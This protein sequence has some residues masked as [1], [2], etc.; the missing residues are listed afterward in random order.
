MHE[1]MYYMEAVQKWGFNGQMTAQFCPVTEVKDIAIDDKSIGLCNG[2]FGHIAAQKKWGGFVNLADTLIGMEY[3]TIGLGCAGELAGVSLNQDFTGKLKFSESA[4]VLSKCK[5][6]ITTDSALMHAADAL[7]VPIV[8]IFGGSLIS[9]NAP[10]NS[11][12]EVVTADIKCRPC[13]GREEFNNCPDPK[14]LNNIETGSVINAIR[15][16]LSRIS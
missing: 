2:S 8:A 16:L 15:N 6:I 14:C 3:K 13:Q 1:A 12:F 7:G 5:M 11:K 9:K 10:I 4:Y